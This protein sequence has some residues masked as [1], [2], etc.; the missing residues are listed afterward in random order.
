MDDVQSERVSRRYVRRRRS[1][2]EIA[3]EVL[4]TCLEPNL[5]TRIMYATNTSWNTFR[6]ILKPL[7]DKGLIEFIETKHRDPRDRNHRIMG[8]YEITDKGRNVLA[9]F[10][11]FKRDLF[12]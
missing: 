8:F 1:K 4:R 5:P 12:G 6:E 9:Q 2:L 7:C 3:I 11:D 10:E